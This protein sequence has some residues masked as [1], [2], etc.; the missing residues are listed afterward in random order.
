M[1]LKSKYKILNLH[2]LPEDY[3]KV[4]TAAFKNEMPVAT[5]IRKI[6]LDHVGS[7]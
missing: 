7:N 4:K 2:L 6:I 3:K 5:Y 1:K